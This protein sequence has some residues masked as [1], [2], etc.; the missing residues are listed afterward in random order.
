[1]L[2][3]AARWKRFG[4]RRVNMMLRREGISINH[5]KVYRLYKEA[6]LMLKR[7][8]KRKTYEKRGMPDRS[9]LPGPN[10][11]WSMDFVSDTTA[12]GRKLRI[13]TL[14]DEVTRECIAI[15]VDT[16]ITGQQVSRYLNKAILFRGRPK[17]ILTDNGPEFTS[18]A[19]NAW[20]YERHIEHVFIE[21]G[22]PMQ[23]GFIESFNG[24]FRDE[25]LNLNWFNS[26][27]DA[28]EI[29]SRWKDE[30]NM[31]RPHSS[32]GDMTP[33]EYA[34]T[35]KNHAATKVASGT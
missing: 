28:R 13:F 32:L 31:V 3:I 22:K 4:Y 29:I 5:K 25:C 26:L 17:E 7:K 9:R 34:R 14:I 19:L 18:N 1:M 35:L 24:R 20:A 23:N 33:V 11:R 6:G 27:H 12:T 21:P 10:D 8:L 30:Y 15:E 2:A 16:S